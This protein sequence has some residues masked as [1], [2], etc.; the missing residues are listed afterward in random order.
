MF[1]KRRLIPFRVITHKYNF[2][3]SA[4]LSPTFSLPPEKKSSSDDFLF[5]AAA[6]VGYTAENFVN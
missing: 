2:G 4:V 5:L 3:L 6:C 1:P